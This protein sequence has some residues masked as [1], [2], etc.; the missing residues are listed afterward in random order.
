MFR[1]STVLL[2]IFI[3]MT[4]RTN[5]TIQMLA[6]LRLK[7]KK[8]SLISV[9][10][11]TEQVDLWNCVYLNVCHLVYSVFFCFSL[12]PCQPQSLTEAHRSPTQ[13]LVDLT[14]TIVVGVQGQ[15]SNNMGE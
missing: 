10:V 4:V 9:C 13:T 2:F 1:R 12:L 14:N 7:G 8:M 3:R 11:F 6:M 15:P 5:M